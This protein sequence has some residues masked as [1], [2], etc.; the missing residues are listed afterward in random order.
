MSLMVPK[1]DCE[2][3]YIQLQA[4][5]EVKFGVNFQTKRFRI[6]FSLNLSSIVET[7]KGDGSLAKKLP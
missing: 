2:C 5:G 4:R 7:C 3:N 6:T 1:H